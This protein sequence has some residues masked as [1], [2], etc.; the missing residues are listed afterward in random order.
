[1]IIIVLYANI[2]I[3]FFS[4]PSEKDLQVHA[5]AVAECVRKN[6]DAFVKG[7]SNVSNKHLKRK[8]S[9]FETFV[10][11]FNREPHLQR[12]AN[13]YPDPL[14]PSNLVTSFILLTRGPKSKQKFDILNSALVCFVRHH[15]MTKIAAGMKNEDAF[16]R[17]LQSTSLTNHFY[18]LFKKI[19]LFQKNIWTNAHQ[20]LKKLFRA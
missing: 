5:L 13:V 11:Y 2:Y 7:L 1:M 9:L 8:D 20:S 6:E 3:Y 4:N 16:S 12:L 19:F 17:E 18:I 10:G 15:K 14:D